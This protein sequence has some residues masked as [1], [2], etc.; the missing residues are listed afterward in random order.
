[1]NRS[2]RLRNRAVCTIILIAFVTLIGASTLLRP[3]AALA[4]PLGNFT[5]NRYSRIEP[6]AGHIYLRYVLDMAEIPT[7]Q[8]K[9]HI[10]RDGDG[11]VS[12]AERATYLADKLEDLKGNLYLSINGLPIPLLTES[13]DL[14]FPAGQGGLSTLRLSLLLHGQFGSTDQNEELNLYYRDDNYS[15]RLG[16]KEIVVQPGEGVSLLRSTIPQHDQSNELRTY[17]Q[18]LLTSPPEEHEARLA[19]PRGSH[20]RCI[21]RFPHRR[22]EPLPA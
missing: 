17:P 22:H 11:Q 15:Q 4:H 16:W 14:S 1:M 7:F 3:Q 6:G 19:S 13:R 5:V 8:E 21:V 9:A 18:D 10:D 12:D 2:L 20:R